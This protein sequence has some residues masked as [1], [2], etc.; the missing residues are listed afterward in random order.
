LIRIITWIYGRTLFIGYI[1]GSL[2][3][4]GIPMEIKKY[5][6]SLTRAYAEERK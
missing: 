2:N 4:G 3:G 1:K 5:N 6:E